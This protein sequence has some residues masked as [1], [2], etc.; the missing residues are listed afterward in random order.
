MLRNSKL[1][2]IIV[3]ALWGFLSALQNFIGWSGT[4]SAV[5]T[6]TSMETIP[7]GSDSWQSTSNPLLIW[8]GALFIVGSKLA[9][10]ALCSIGAVGMWRFRNADQSDYKAAK[11]IALCGCAVAVIMLFGGFIVI[12]EVWFELWRS[13]SM[14]APVLDSAFR[15][16]AMILLTAIFVAT[17]D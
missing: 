16:G 9:T 5:E 14:R 1:A 13:E 2:L 17:E 11:N 6:A 4:L 8:I 7:G 15:Y 3:V 10:G 12:A